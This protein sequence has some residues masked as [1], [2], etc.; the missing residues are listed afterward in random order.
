MLKVESNFGYRARQPTNSLNIFAV[1]LLS[2]PASQAFVKSSGR[3][4][5]KFSGG[6]YG[7]RGAQAYNGVWGRA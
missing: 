1:D 7:E 2:A 3:I 4:I 6:P 5:R